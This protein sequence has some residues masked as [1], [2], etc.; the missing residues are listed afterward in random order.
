MQEQPPGFQVTR[1]KFY[2]CFRCHTF[3]QALQSDKQCQPLGQ[4]NGTLC[5]LYRCLNSI[6]STHC[7]SSEPFSSLSGYQMVISPSLNMQCPLWGQWCTCRPL[8]HLNDWLTTYTFSLYS[9]YWTVLLALWTLDERS[10]FLH[11]I[12][13]H[14][15]NNSVKPQKTQSL[16]FSQNNHPSPLPDP[17]NPHSLS[18]FLFCTTK[19]FHFPTSQCFSRQWPLL[20]PALSFSLL[21][22]QM[23]LFFW[24]PPPMSLCILSFPPCWSCTLIQP[25]P[26]PAPTTNHAFHIH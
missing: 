4:Q 9:L 10:M 25:A 24:V 14:P 17:P 26:I 15:P 12:D 19:H 11:N 16:C 8:P 20:C 23:V 5:L 3:T 7:T 18:N 22:S 1:L 13:N 21:L 6:T 2:S